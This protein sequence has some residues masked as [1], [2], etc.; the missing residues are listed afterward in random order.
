M[1]IKKLLPSYIVSPALTLD[2]WLN[3]LSIVVILLFL[4]SLLLGIFVP[5]YTDEV[6]TKI[7]QARFFAEGGKIVTLFPQCGAS[8]IVDTP[9]TWYPAA[10]I[11]AFLYAGLEP[12]G[13]R[14]SG[15]AMA[16]VWVT[17]SFWGILKITSIRQYSIYLYAAIAVILGLGVLPFMLIL[18]RSEQWLILL[19]T[20]YCFFPIISRRVISHESTLNKWGLF[21]VFCLVTSLFFYSHPKAIFFFPLVIVSVFYTFGIKNRLFLGLSI[22]FLV[23]CTFQSVLLAKTLTHCED[24]PKL[25]AILSSQTLD[26]KLIKTSPVAFITTATENIINAPNSI[27]NYVLFSNNYQSGWLPAVNEGSLTFAVRFV[28]DISQALLL[29]CLWS[30]MLLP[31]FF[32]YKLV[33]SA[34]NREN[35]FLVLALWIGL[36]GHLAIFSTWNFYGAALVL[37][38]SLLILVL[39]GADSFQ[40]AMQRLWAKCVLLIALVLSLSSF[41]VLFNT[42][43]PKLILNSHSDK[44]LIVGQPLSVSAFNFSTQRLRVRAL[45]KTCGIN[46]DDSSHLVIDDLTYFA[47]E[48]LHQPVHV[49]YLYG[50]GFGLDVAGDRVQPFLTK[51]ASDGIIARCTYL[52][53]FYKDKALRDNNYCCV[54]ISTNK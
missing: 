14:I 11:Y 22:C 8:F 17:L 20:L 10:M 44:G 25:S 42:I 23:I 41:Y 31:L 2:K 40:L 6:A 3:A 27:T 54:N 50:G 38:L 5:L 51:I 49:I 4:A 18:A 39:L 47:F 35:F 21:F 46:G 53:E 43:L 32:F 36:V 48:R 1:L 37:P 9:L 24:A 34:K 7:L 52:P 26:F 19:I 45:A 15:V 12:L 28:N 30:A 33:N 16:L 13:I 29:T